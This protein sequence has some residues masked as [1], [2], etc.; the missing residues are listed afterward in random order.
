V[1]GAK[2]LLHDLHCIKFSIEAILFLLVN[3]C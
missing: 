3:E 2:F 1:K